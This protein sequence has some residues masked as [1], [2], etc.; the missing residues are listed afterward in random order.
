MVVFAENTYAFVQEKEMAF[1][2]N[3]LLERRG[4][5]TWLLRDYRTSFNGRGGKRGVALTQI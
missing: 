2:F 4:G 3:P 1:Y 5:A